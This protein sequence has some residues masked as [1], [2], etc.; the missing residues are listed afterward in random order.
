MLVVISDLHFVDGTSGN[1]NLPAKAF[2]QVFLSSIVGLAQK[3]KATELKLLLL[4]DI[5]DLIRSAQWFDDA[6][7]DRLWGKYG[8][9]DIPRPRPHSRTEKRCL[10]I[11]GR[12]PESGLREDVP[13]NTILYQNWGTFHFFRTFHKHL[14]QMAEKEYDIENY[15][16]PVEIVYVVGNHD[17]PVNLYPAVRDELQKQLG[18]TITSETVDGDIDGEWW[19]KYDFTDEAYGVFTRHGHQFD[20]YN[21]NG[22][23]AYTRED[24]LQVPIGDVIATEIAVNLVVTL[25]S[26][27]GEFPEITDELVEA[28][29][30][31]DNVRPLGRLM[32]WFYSKMNE[33]DN[34]RIREAMDITIDTVVENFFEIE[35]VQNWKNPNTHVDELIRAASKRPFQRVLDFVMNHSDASRLIELLLPVADRYL[36]EGGIDDY[37][38]GA[39][40]EDVWKAEDSPIRYVLYGHTHQP[41]LKPL[42]SINGRDVIYINTGTWRE[43]L[44]RTISLD[45][46]AN[47]VSIKQLTYQVFYNEEE[48]KKNKEMGTIGFDSWTGHQQKQY[49]KSAEKGKQDL[50]V[51]GG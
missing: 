47:F 44:H 29:Q 7:E 23:D 43:R 5:P 36:K 22:T 33:Q 14:Q 6:P 45:K 38:E 10:D 16:I 4:G 25:E 39:F 41:L 19:Y 28:M 27:R 13:V 2:E 35:F 50:D 24:H 11:L 3:N 34:E 37:M 18:L 42:D 12:F 8:L 21:Y 49:A 40:Y 48:D 9:A 15:S 32:E 1:H 31:V 20:I 46:T 26:L 17:R 30:A 51:K